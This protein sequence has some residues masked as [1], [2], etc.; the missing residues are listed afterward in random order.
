MTTKNKA[1]QKLGSTGGKAT[2]KKYGKAHYSRMGKLSAAKRWK[3][4]VEEIERKLA[5]GELS[6]DD[7]TNCLLTK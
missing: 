6:S 3:K 4:N 2:S 7:V 1:A 5:S